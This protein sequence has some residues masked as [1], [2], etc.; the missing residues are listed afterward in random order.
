MIGTEQLIGQL[1]RVIA[2]RGNA[3]PVEERGA[4]LLG[5]QEA[6]K[7]IA[8]FIFLFTLGGA[9]ML[10]PMVAPGQIRADYATFGI[11]YALQV[12]LPLEFLSTVL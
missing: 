8:Q 7:Q 12:R 10:Q 6:L 11:I 3:L 2:N 5:P 9:L 1:W 4:K